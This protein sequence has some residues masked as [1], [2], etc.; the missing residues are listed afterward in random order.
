MTWQEKYDYYINQGVSPEKARQLADTT[1]PAVTVT[2][3]DPNETGITA[4]AQA[5]DDKFHSYYDRGM[6]GHTWERIKKDGAF[7]EKFNDLLDQVIAGGK[8][9]LMGDREKI[10]QYMNMGL[11]T[12]FDYDNYKEDQTKA[13]IEAAKEPVY[14]MEM[15]PEMLKLQDIINETI[16]TKPEF[17]PETAEAWKPQIGEMYAPVE[18]NLERIQRERWSSRFGGGGT[19]TG[20]QARKDFETW[21]SVEAEKQKM[22]MAYAENEYNKKWQDYVNSINQSFD[23]EKFK[24]EGKRFTSIQERD[25]YWKNMERGW[26]LNDLTSQRLYESQKEA[27]DRQFYEQL[28]LK[29]RPPEKQWWEHVLPIAGQVG[30]AAL[31]GGF[32]VPLTAGVNAAQYGHKFWQD[33]H[34]NP[35]SQYAPY[36]Y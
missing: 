10:E 18:K 13:E 28:A 23:I 1:D 33:I 9:V 32:S 3:R 36:G 6:P 29:M 14:K 12:Q 24:D 15:T 5:V 30:L 19:G 35:T 2:G 8:T 4:A 31:T 22:A 21:G 11:F 7:R 26:S 20:F 17:N 34:S 16:A 27:R 25:D